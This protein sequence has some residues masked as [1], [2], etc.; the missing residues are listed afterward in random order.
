VSQRSI[1][2][3]GQEQVRRLLRAHGARAIKALESGLSAE[4]EEI[5]T[6]AKEITPFDTGN[7]RES[8]WVDHPRTTGHRVIVELGFGNASTAYAIHVHERMDLQHK[9]QTQAKF[10]ETPA[11]EAADGLAERMAEHVRKEMGL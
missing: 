6:K 4:A 11:W 10:L 7:L 8:G 2:I 5:M 9:G 3:R 1:L